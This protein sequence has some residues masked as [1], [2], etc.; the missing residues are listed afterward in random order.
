MIYQPPPQKKKIEK[1]TPRN[2]KHAKQSTKHEVAGVS[3][4]LLVNPKK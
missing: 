2:K 1:E 4:N 3:P